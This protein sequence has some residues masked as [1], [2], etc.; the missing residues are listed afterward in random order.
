MWKKN[1]FRYE[2]REDDVIVLIIEILNDYIWV[3]PDQRGWPCFC[4]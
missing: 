3:F 2:M 1:I 4:V